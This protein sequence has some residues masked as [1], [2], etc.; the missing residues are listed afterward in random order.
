MT[1]LHYH[2][3]YCEENIWHLCREPGRAGRGGRVIFISNPERTCPIWSAQGSPTRDMPVFWDYHVIY[4]SREPRHRVWDPDSRLEN[5]A[6]FVQYLKASFRRA[7]PAPFQPLFRMVQAETFLKEFSS[8][9]R[10][11]LLPD[12]AWLHPPP[13]WPPIQNQAVH[14]LDMWIDMNNNF[15]GEIL[16]L[17]AIW[18]IFLRDEA[19]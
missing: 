16:N 9:R 10:H 18:K 5:G 13:P 15:H 19:P 7:L 3:F 11:M 17:D 14:N 4:L 2:P 12:G 1:P 8:D 6:P